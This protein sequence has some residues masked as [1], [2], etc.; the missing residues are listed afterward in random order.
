[1]TVDDVR[2]NNKE[3]FRCA[4]TNGNVKTVRFFMQ[5]LTLD[6]DVRANNNE[7]FRYASTAI[8][9]QSDCFHRS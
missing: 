3:A 9:K 1:M 4:C 8:P 6:D 2:T 5:K 7:A